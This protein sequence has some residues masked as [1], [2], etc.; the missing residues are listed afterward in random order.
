MQTWYMSLYSSAN[1]YG[2]WRHNAGIIQTDANNVYVFQDYHTTNR[3][4]T[5]CTF[6]KLVKHYY[7]IPRS[8]QKS[9]FF[10]IDLQNPQ[11]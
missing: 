3:Y 2:N 6:S 9:Y 8:R 7:R 11:G 1:Q 4:A 5:T 10:N